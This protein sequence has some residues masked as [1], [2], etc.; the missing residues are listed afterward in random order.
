MKVLSKNNMK[1]SVLSPVHK[2]SVSTNQVT[3]WPA[4][5]RTSVMRHCQCGNAVAKLLYVP[6]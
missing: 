2:R 3:L 1:L 6:I 5:S 4:V